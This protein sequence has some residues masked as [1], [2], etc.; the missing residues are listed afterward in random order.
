MEL[1]PGR[2]H[3]TAYQSTA[4]T[5]RPREQILDELARLD[6]EG[7]H[8]TERGSTYLVYAPRPQTVWTAGRATGTAI[9]VA[10]LALLLSA[11]N[12]LWILL[13]PLSLGAFLPLLIEDHTMLAV[14]VVEEEDT[15]G[16][17]R[18]TIHG[19]VW[20]DLGQVLD[21]YLGRLPAAPVDPVGSPADP[22][23]PVIGGDLPATVP[24]AAGSAEAMRLTGD[25]A[26]D[27]ATQRITPD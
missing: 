16:V 4:R 15:P 13:L 9:A 18:L 3:G 11:A 8:V 10:L 23:D 21:G 12:V 24:P 26:D 7:A 2:V 1:L 19:Q 14:G 20:G 25:E 5:A 6:A 22:G 17:T 27:P